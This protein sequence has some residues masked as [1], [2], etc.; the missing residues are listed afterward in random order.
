MTEP[1]LALYWRTVRHLRGAQL[2]CLVRRRVFGRRTLA[3][4]VG[5]PAQLRWLP[6]APEFPE[7]NPS[8]SRDM[9]E[10]RA[11]DFLNVPTVVAER[12]PWS[13]TEYPKLWYY[14][15]NYCDFLNV[16]LTRPG[17]ERLL[18][19]AYSLALDWSDRNATGGEIGWEPY[20]LSLRIVNWLK[21]LTRNARRLEELGENRA[22]D[23]I[24]ASLRSQALTLERQFE[25]DLRANHL[26]K[27][28][29]ALIF[30]GALLDSPESSRWLDESRR[31][32]R[33]EIR[34]QVLPDGGHFER[35]PMYHAQALEDFLDLETLT[36][37]CGGTAGCDLGLSG[38]IERMAAF[39][40]AILHPDGEIPLLNDAALGVARPARELLALSRARGAATIPT[41]RGVRVTVLGEAGYAVI[42]EAES[43]SCLIFD[44]G[45]LGPDHQLGHA[46]CD[47]LSYE[48]SLH[49]QRVV[50]DTGVSTYERGPERH[51]E[52]STAAHNTVRIDAQEQA[53][54]WASFRVGRR[55]R[56][57][58]IEA[59][60]IRGCQ[61]MRGRHFGYEHC[62][63]IHCRTVVH[64]PGNGWFV[65]D[66]LSGTGRH[67]VESFVH[68][69]PAIEV[70]A[71]TEARYVPPELSHGADGDPSGV[72]PMRPRWI[73][74]FGEHRYFFM[75]WGGGELTLS[76]SWYAPE[77]GLR[78]NRAVIHWTWAGD[79]PAAMLY[80]FVPADVTPP[81]VRR[82]DGDTIEVAG[83]T[84]RLN[85]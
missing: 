82:V 11:W 52:R 7:W 6:H 21:F 68:F 39:L 83:A 22:L 4:H 18:R 36:S 45:P 61:T 56:V 74:Q 17:D 23:Q 35:S 25:K 14:H 10:T 72:E 63:V 57:G 42:R 9:L 20:T 46:H 31:L 58:R 54:I 48:L 85:S 29:K 67:R 33:R 12:V 47:V 59:R 62:G 32:L 70:A 8:W 80:A 37:A 75:T 71:C 24:L 15:L 5:G 53:E 2:G 84:M 26:L 1:S 81:V 34:E 28:I 78:Q 65:L 55:P 38:P 66:S 79:L 43:A 40:E 60:D 16:D 50:V 76:G 77:F 27:N 3:K 69:H 73:V 30:A 64:A 41:R 13:G 19:S 49:G 51:Y 44:A